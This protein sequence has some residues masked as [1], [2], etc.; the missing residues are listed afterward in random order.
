MSGQILAFSVFAFVASITPGPTNILA[1]A[2]GSR[3]GV[4]A[5]LPFVVGA[6]AGASALLLITTLG[7]AQF[8][9][10]YPAVQ[11]ILAWGGTLWLSVMACKLFHAPPA[12]PGRVDSLQPVPGWHHGAALQ[13]VNPKTWIMALTV[14]ALFLAPGEEKISHNL[15]LAL[16]FFLVTCPCIAMW[17]WMGKSSNRLLKTATQRV[18]LNRALAILL[19]VSVWWALLG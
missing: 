16:I 18:L 13:V 9:F 8:F 12:T 10:D 1:L 11:Q 2:S 5:T 14:G 3:A 6:S 7:L 4:R 15:Q 17:A 19:A